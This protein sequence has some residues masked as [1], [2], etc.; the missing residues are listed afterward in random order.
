[1]VLWFMAHNKK[2]F[3][4]RDD[5]FNNHNAHEALRIRLEESTKTSIGLA[6]VHY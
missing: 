5:H 4:E 1:M 6:R 3:K 2:D